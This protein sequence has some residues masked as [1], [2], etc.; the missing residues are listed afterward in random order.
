[1]FTSD[2]LE[3]P[4]EN[5]ISAMV[6]W[7]NGSLSSHPFRDSTGQMNLCHGEMTIP[8][9]NSSTMLCPYFSWLTVSWLHAILA[10]IGEKH[11]EGFM[12]SVHSILLVS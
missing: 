11:L 3:N 1:M 10:K 6:H 7:M 5:P 8:Y 2:I 4:M 9:W 12:V